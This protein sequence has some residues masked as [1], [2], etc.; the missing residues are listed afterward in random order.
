MT[1]RQVG[2]EETRMRHYLPFFVGWDHDVHADVERSTTELGNAHAKQSEVRLELTGD[3][4]QLKRW[5][6]EIDAPV[7]ISDG[8]P[9]IVARIPT[10]KGE[11]TVR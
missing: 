3:A 8:P 5:L 9:G 7:S 1:W 6:G 10:S 2:F 4:D 11:L